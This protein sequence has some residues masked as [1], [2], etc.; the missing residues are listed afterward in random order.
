[1][2]PSRNGPRALQCAAA[3]LLVLAAASTA[4]AD[5]IVSTGVNNQG[6]D[7]VLLNDA[8]NVSIVTGSINSGAFDVEFV[9][10][11][12]NLNADASGQAKISAASSNDPF[13]N[14]RFYLD[15]GYF[16]RAV[17]N[18]NSATDGDL[19][20]EVTGINIAGGLFQQTVQVDNNGQNFF[21]I[22][23][24]NGQLIGSIELTGVTPVIFEDLRQVRIG[25]AQS[26]PP[27]VPEPST[28]L[29]FG[30]AVVG[31]AARLRHRFA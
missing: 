10:E 30:T 3:L 21:T 18:L 27:T 25:G 9:S 24:I 1:M 23:A 5:I 4:H 8:T 12:G 16:T 20:I 28:M 6:T 13:D 31:F 7:N 11:G 14:I 2:T 19:L 15:S 26:A 29:L 17:F 22:D